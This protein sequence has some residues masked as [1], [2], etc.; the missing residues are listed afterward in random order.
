[1]IRNNICLN[2]H[3]LGCD[4]Q[5]ADQIDY[6]QEQGEIYGP[7]NVLVIG[8]STGY[9]L[10]SRIVAAFA[11]NAKSIGVYYERPGS[12][13]RSG[14]AGFYNDL[15][16]IRA[17][18]K[19]GPAAWSINGDAFSDEVKEQ[20]ISTIRK[21]L[22]Q[23]DLVVYSLAAPVRTDPDT[24][25]TYRSVIKP[26]G[27]RYCA[28]TLDSASGRFVD[29]ELEP[30]TQEEIHATVKVMG[31]EDWERWID[32]LKNAHALTEDAT[33]VAYS[34]IGPLATHKM[35]RLGTIGKAKEH[36]EETAHRLDQLLA[37]DGGQ[38]FV[39]VNKALVTR[40]SAVIP[41]VP[42]YISLLFKVMKNRGIHENCIHQMYRLFRDRL[43]AGGDVAT[44]E[45]R[46]IRMDD[47]EMREEVQS[48]VDL[49]WT[50][51]TEE[52]LKELADFDGYWDAFLQFH[53]FGVDGVDY[54]AEVTP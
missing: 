30:A 41:V 2:A 20:V 42:L 12:D 16:F 10:A 3:P 5:V 45:E 1:M 13:K 37:Q 22:G 28:V 7:K 26:I 27:E 14:S 21:N 34:Y 44:D 46:R 23:V 43:Y 17:A 38:A 31:G 53:G 29:F 4:K 50:R 19:D 51:L 9:G 47:Y 15:A 11:C 24:G 39:S 25:K 33:T 48:E 40:A 8:S 32:A 49:L 52:N 35:Y 6:V 54:E 36:L 18:E